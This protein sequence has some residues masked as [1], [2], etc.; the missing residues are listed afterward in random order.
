V[1]LSTGSITRQPLP[2]EEAMRLLLG[3]KGLGAYLL[4]NETPAGVDPLSPQNPLILNVGPL[5]GTN[6]P[7]AGRFGA[8][9]KSP[10]TGTY[11][12][13]YCGGFFG[14]TMK[15]AGYDAIILQGAAPEP[16]MLVIDDDRVEIRSAHQL[17]GATIIQATER[18]RSEFGPGWESLVIGPPGEKGSNIASIFNDTRALARGGVGAVMGSK[19]LKAIVARGDGKVYLADRARYDR[20][21]QLATR[22]IR[23]S[24]A[25]TRMTADGTANI[26]EFVN[27]VGALPTRNFQAG[28]F[29]QADEISGSA[30]SE[31]SWVKLYACFGCPIACSKITR[32]VDGKVLEGPEYETIFALGSNCAIGSQEDIIR[33]SWVCDEYG[34]DTISAGG[35]VG[36]VMELFEKGL[37]TTADLDGIEPRWGHSPSALALVEKMAKMEGCGEWL[38]Q[39]VAA[40][41]R[42]YP[43]SEAFAMHAKGLEMPAYHPN[44]AKGMALGYAV[45]ERGACHLRGAPLTE[46]L[47]GADP[48]TPQGKA[49]LFRDHQ[50]ESA[51]WNSAVLCCFPGYGMSLK[52][53]WQLV[54][55]ATG[56]E[57]TTP[58]E[59][60]LVGERIST[61]AR[62]FNTRE[63]FTRQ[64]DTLPARNLSQPM[65]AGPA[66]GHVVELAAMLDQYY[67]LVGWDTNG[68]PTQQQLNRLGLEPLLP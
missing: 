57:Y 43:G 53:L 59:F 28:Q 29:E 32:P 20:A 63:G 42:R 9:T 11:S 13:A 33:L 56:F 52:E 7:T 38:S 48:L 22:A 27:A 51:L 3:G 34:M 5:T 39:G 17:W 23:M 14:Q 46:V 2:G 25:I 15:Y 24:S 26:L 8:T 50:A 30:F 61:F 44:A 64:Q 18:L 68:V 1:D 41:A 66:K 58:K 16:V 62:L 36:F 19:N 31:K 6:A 21:H 49:R 37:I 60:E 54:N 55:A 67:A 45:S 40:I 4:Y 10:A 65:P 47:G 35:I 12:D